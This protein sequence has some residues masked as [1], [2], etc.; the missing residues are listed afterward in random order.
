VIARIWTWAKGVGR[1]WIVVFFIALFILTFLPRCS[2]AAEFEAQAGA[3]IVRGE[4]WAAA[5]LLY[6]PDV[7]PNKADVRCRILLYG[8]SNL[9]PVTVPA[10]TTVHHSGP[11]TF[12][13]TTPAYQMDRSQDQNAQVGCQLLSGYKHWRLGL[14]VQNIMRTDLQ[15]AGGMAFWLTARYEFTHHFAVEYSHSSNA[16]TK[17]P[18]LG[19]DFAL[20]AWRF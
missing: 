16:G 9:G 18:N 10:V 4:T 7:V 20:L 11:L 6:F 5:A 19:S 15:N 13:D 8:P 2:R 17:Q 1:W 3:K 14:G 12:T